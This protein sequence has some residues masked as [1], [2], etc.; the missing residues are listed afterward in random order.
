MPAWVGHLLLVWGSGAGCVACLLFAGVSL[1][2]AQGNTE[3][4]G[5][6]GAGKWKAVVTE[7]RR[8]HKAGRPTLV[9]TTSVE[10]S[11]ALAKLLDEDGALRHSCAS[12]CHLY[13]LA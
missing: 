13:S 7:I 6:A 10:R 12:R 9:G 8:M 1:R 2:F 3:P 4:R 11:E 5:C